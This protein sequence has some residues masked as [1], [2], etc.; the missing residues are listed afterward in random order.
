MMLLVVRGEHLDLE[1]GRGHQGNS[2][3]AVVSICSER[4][5]IFVLTTWLV[6][7]PKIVSTVPPHGKVSI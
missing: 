6:S 5:I 2:N 1:R 3:R 4:N 7:P